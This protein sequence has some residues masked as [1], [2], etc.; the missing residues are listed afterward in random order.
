MQSKTITIQGF[1][2]QEFKKEMR[3]MFKMELQIF[4]KTFLK[5]S[6]CDFLTRKQTALLLQIDLSTLHR[7]TYD[8]K[9]IAV[10]KIGTRVYYE[11]AAIEKLL[12][13]N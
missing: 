7:W 2:V 6:E 4:S 9:K 12:K 5:N 1:T 8:D 10:K 11:K 13:S 3:E